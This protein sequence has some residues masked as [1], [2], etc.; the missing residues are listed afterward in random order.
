MVKQRPSEADIINAGICSVPTARFVVPTAILGVLHFLPGRRGSLQTDRNERIIT[1][2]RN[3]C[4]PMSSAR[5][6]IRTCRPGSHLI[7][8]KEER[9][10]CS[11]AGLLNLFWDMD[12][13]MPL[14]ATMHHLELVKSWKIERPQRRQPALLGSVKHRI[15]DEV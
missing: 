12:P 15:L 6:Q 5:P 4:E 2:F 8:V 9:Q 3:H 14:K 11:D 10:T 7:T 13:K 1:R